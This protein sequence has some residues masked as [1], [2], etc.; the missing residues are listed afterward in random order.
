MGH[1]GSKTASD[2]QFIQAIKPKI[3]IISAGRNNRYGHPNQE[4][5]DTMKK[6]QVKL[7]S[8]QKDGMISYRYSRFESYFTTKWKGDLNDLN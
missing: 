2:P 8:T 4:T 5:L 1:H 3:G 7:I 6:E